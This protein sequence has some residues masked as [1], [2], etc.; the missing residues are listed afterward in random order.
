MADLRAESRI[1][2]QD[3]EVSSAFFP[4]E[5]VTLEMANTVALGLEYDG[6]VGPIFQPAAL[7]DEL[8]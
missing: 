8:D 1:A 3:L 5:A 2:L 6:S 7:R 4:H